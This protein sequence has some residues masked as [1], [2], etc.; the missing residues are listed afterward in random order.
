MPLWA[1]V[2]LFLCQC[3]LLVQR[4]GCS[5]CHSALCWSDRIRFLDW[6][7]S[8]SC[9]LECSE[10]WISSFDCIMNIVEL[11]EWN[12][13]CSNILLDSAVARWCSYCK[14]G[15]FCNVATGRQLT[16][17]PWTPGSV[18]PTE[19]TLLAPLRLGCHGVCCGGARCGARRIR[20]GAPPPEECAQH[21]P[22]LRLQHA[23]PHLPGPQ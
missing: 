4:L 16:T 15:S 22:A 18:Q 20:L 10:G 7:S 9:Y 8:L 1:P 17:Y 23:P 21:L 14:M 6:R 5:L 3:W 12:V 13:T 2:C 19:D 11:C